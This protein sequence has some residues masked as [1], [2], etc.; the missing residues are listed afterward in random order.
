MLRHEIVLGPY[1]MLLDFK[2]IEAI[3][4][5]AVVEEKYIGSI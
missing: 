5:P 3:E 2:F 1:T 4:L